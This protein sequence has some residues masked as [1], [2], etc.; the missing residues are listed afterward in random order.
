MFGLISQMNVIPDK[1]DELVRIIAEATRG[2]PGCLSYVIAKDAARDDAIWI[3]EIWNNRESH[4]SSLNLPAVQA[5]MTK[6]RPLITGM[7][8]RAETLPVAGL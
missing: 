6:G 7:G 5:A 3:T 1:R 8:I 2:M 4:A